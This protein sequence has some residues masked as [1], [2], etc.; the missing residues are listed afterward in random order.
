LT[1]TDFCDK[2]LDFCDKFFASSLNISYSLSK[3]YR[4][5]GLKPLV[6]KLSEKL[7]YDLNAQQLSIGTKVNP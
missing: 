6:K 1:H 7:L 2:F 5:K 3:I 4:G